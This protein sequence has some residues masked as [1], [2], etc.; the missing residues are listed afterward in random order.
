VRV[1]VV[2]NRYRSA[3]PSGEDA[4]VETEAELLREHG[5]EVCRLEA[6]SDDIAGWPAR[7]RALVPARV[8]WSRD[9]V[10]SVGAAIEAHRPD[11][12]HVH[13]TFPLLSPAVFRAARS[14][15]VPVVAT[16]HNFRP[17]CPAATF[18][19][20]GRIC[21]DCLGRVPVPAVR[22]R[23]YRSSALATAPIAVSDAL[24]AVI[25]TWSGSVETFITPSA[26]VR[27]KYIEAGWAPEK[28]VVKPNATLDRDVA[29]RSGPGDGFVYLGRLVEEKGLDML[30]DAWGTA[31]ADG[32]E[33]LTIVGS[34]DI[35]DRLRRRSARLRGV[36]FTGLLSRG[37]AL[38]VLRRARALVVPSVWYEVFGLVVLEA[39]ALHV[40]V[41]APRLG[42]LPELV[43]HGRSGLTYAPDS[44]DGLAAALQRLARSPGLASALGHGARE[45]FDREYS[46]A[47]A[48]TRLIEIYR[49][50]IGA[51]D[52]T[53][54][55]EQQMALAN[56]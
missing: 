5:V 21:E 56:G 23:C 38:D 7:K 13:N 45:L 19:R 4:V 33:R 28:L 50:A 46:P 22:H 16:L 55:G 15:G 44:S 36:S 32:G 27:S 43:R 54:R 37:D 51:R 30:L 25:G 35:G 53:P 34:G 31:F 41:V 8:V 47:V 49:T 1:L 17:L 11:V 3:Q 42:G 48:T 10:R 40:P 26:F 9:G 52:G 39:Y 14:A 12:V 18:F 29:P 6:A 2:H 20:D 24:H